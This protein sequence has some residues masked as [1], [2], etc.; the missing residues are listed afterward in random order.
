MPEC[1]R[2]AHDGRRCAAACLSCKGPPETN[3][4]G[5]TFISLDAGGWSGQTLGEI[6]AAEALASDTADDC[7]QAGEKAAFEMAECEE[8][9]PGAGCDPHA[10][11]ADPAAGLETCAPE[12]VAEPEPDSPLEMA[13]KLAYTFT[14]L[15]TAEFD[16]VRSL[17][18]G[19]N[20]SDIGRRTGLT[21]A[22]V[23]ARV[24]QLARKHPAFLF[25]RT[26][27]RAAG[28]PGRHI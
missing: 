2:C 14:E 17:M 5:Q 10:A 20:M 11:G 3:H 24:K 18:R 27:K 1:H 13:R 16:L 15:E 4:K 9:E 7:D 23:S 8:L 12:H 6:E 22:G 19:D 28:Q 21:R 26:G 25:L